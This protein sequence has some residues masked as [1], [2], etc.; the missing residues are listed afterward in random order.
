MEHFAEKVRADLD[1][2]FL[3]TGCD[4]WGGGLGHLEEFFQVP[5]QTFLI[6]LR[7][8]EVEGGHGRL[9]RPFVRLEFQIDAIRVVSLAPF[10]LGDPK[11][12]HLSLPSPSE[13][14]TA[15]RC[16]LALSTS[17]PRNT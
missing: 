10:V 17:S 1:H 14:R 13:T 12:R 5:A 8:F 16:P 4:R 7:D 3:D 15:F 11:P 6:L 9:T 2:S